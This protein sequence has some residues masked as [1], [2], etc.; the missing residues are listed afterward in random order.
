MFK[1]EIQEKLEKIFGFGKTTYN[2]PS[3]AFEQDTLFVVIDSSRSNAGQGNVNAKVEGTLT[4]FS[5]NDRFPYGFFNKRI[6]KASP[7][8]TEKFFFYDIDVDVAGSPARLIDISERRTKFVY[9]Y[10]EQY[11]PNQGELTSVEFDEGVEE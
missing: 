8:L 6:T 1:K 5:K 11:D 10:S 2:A 3:D 7:A 4:V 9:W